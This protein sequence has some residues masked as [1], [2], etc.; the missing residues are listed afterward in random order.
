MNI[1]FDIYLF[2]CLFV[3]IAIDGHTRNVN[4]SLLAFIFLFS[5]NGSQ[6]LLRDRLFAGAS[7][8]YW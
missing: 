4:I 7:K 5:I 8:K 2:I 1:T 6:T 3:I